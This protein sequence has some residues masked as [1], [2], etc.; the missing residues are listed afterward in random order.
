[1]PAMTARASTIEELA[2]RMSR[3]RSAESARR[4]LNIQVRPDDVFIATYPKCGTTWTQQIVHQLRTGGSM[5]FE[6]ICAVVPWLESAWDMHQDPDADQDWKPRAFKSHLDWERIPKGGRYI[7][8]LRDP[9]TALVSFHRF[10]EGYVIEPGAIPLDV[11][12][13][14]WVMS[15]TLSGRIWEFVVS[16]WR[17]AADPAV[18][19]LAYE[20]MVADPLATVRRI[21]EF[22]DLADRHRIEVAVTNSTREFMAQHRRQF[23]DHLLRAAID[24]RMG[25]PPGGSSAKVQDV[26]STSALSHDVE[27]E[28]EEMWAAIVTPATG[29]ETYDDMRVAVAAGGSDPR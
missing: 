11:F 14:Q 4:G 10:F 2:E 7:H 8:V 17:R 29:F 12:V 3:F 27:R 19:I 25:L 20:D 13:R 16:W 18:L 22:L 9:K 28:V 24:P 1:M 21:A 6:E 5:D 26:G 23:D 15:G